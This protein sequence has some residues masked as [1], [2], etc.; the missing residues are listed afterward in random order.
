MLHNEEEKEFV[1][2]KAKGRKEELRLRG[3]DFDGNLK[4]AFVS[5]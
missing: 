1:K 4:N 3:R 5:G 2:N